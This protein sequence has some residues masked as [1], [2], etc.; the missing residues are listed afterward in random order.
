MTIGLV[1]RYARQHQGRD[2]VGIVYSTIN[3]EFS[4]ISLLHLPSN[5]FRPCTTVSADIVDDGG[6]HSFPLPVIP[7][8]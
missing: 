5:S 2:I 3:Q 8:N 4:G 1:L 6:R 7:L